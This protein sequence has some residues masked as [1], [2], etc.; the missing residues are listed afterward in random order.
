MLGSLKKE[1]YNGRICKRYTRRT[2]S[3]LGLCLK[4][5]R[6]SSAITPAILKRTMK[7]RKS[8]KSHGERTI[9]NKYHDNKPDH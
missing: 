3:H 8:T 4:R 2:C 9:K 1:I 6:S 5:A 7:T